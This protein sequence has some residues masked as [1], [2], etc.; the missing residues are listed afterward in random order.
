MWS[1]GGTSAK[2]GRAPAHD[3]RGASLRHEELQLPVAGGDGDV[4]VLHVAEVAEDLTDL[5]HLPLQPDEVDVAVL[6]LRELEVDG[7]V[8][9]GEP[10]GEAQDHTALV[11]EVDDRARL[12]HEVAV[13]AQGGIERGAAEPGGGGGVHVRILAAA[14][15]RSFTARPHAFT[16][17]TRT[18]SRSI[19]P[20]PMS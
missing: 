15:P 11:A 7:V 10:A 6:A 20:R 3:G 14:L 19:S 12:G 4:L 1:L 16:L 13:Q 2:T 5:R 17:R 18:L 9:H 8:P